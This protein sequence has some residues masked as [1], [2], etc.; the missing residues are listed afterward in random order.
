ME[1]SFYQ[2]H[3]RYWIPHPALRNN[4]ND[5]YTFDLLGVEITKSARYTY[6]ISGDNDRFTATATTERLDDDP[7]VD[8]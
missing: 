4:K 3:D 8:T 6:T 2:N 1:R 5:Q 7:A